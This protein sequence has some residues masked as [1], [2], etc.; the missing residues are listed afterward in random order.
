MGKGVLL[1]VG[2][3]RDEIAPA[4]LGLDA[5]DRETVDRTMTELDGT[6]TKSRLGAN[7]ILGVSLACARAAAG[8]AYVISHRSGETEDSIIEDI[9]AHRKRIISVKDGEIVEDRPNAAL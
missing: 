8:F 1:A 9:A 6:E 5:A 3:V 7:S 2:N 4:V